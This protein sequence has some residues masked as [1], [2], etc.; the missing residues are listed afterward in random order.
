MVTVEVL[1]VVPPYT[2]NFMLQSVLA[3]FNKLVATP[4]VLLDVGKMDLSQP[5]TDW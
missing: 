1:G 4:Q 2:C 3:F 5:V